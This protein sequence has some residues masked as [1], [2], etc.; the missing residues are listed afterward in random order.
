VP[1]EPLLVV[2]EELLVEVLVDDDELLVEVLVD[3]EVLVDEDV[4]ELPPAPPLPSSSSSSSSPVVALAQAAMTAKTTMPAHTMDRA[5]TECWC[6]MN[7]SPKPGRGRPALV[8]R[9]SPSSVYALCGLTFLP[10]RVA[11][12]AR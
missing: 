2:E 3:D 6:P 4:D 1:P 5:S 10:V 9:A 12:L 8:T 7:G 11:V